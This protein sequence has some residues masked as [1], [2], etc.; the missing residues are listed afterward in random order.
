MSRKRDIHVTPHPKGGWQTM[1]EGASRAS[2]RHDTQLK[3]IGHG[4]DLA[5]RDKVKLVIHRKDGTI[6]G[7][8]SHG[9]DPQP[10]KDGK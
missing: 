9:G 7:D 5:K 1:R 10:P 8:D 6:R 3:A 2:S 4:R